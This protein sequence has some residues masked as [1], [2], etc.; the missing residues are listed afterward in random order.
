[1]RRQP[2]SVILFDEIEKAHPDVFNLLLQILEDGILHDGEGRLINFRQT[3]I[4]LT[5]N[6]GSDF[7]SQKINLGFASKNKTS[8]QEITKNV[9]KEIKNILS[10]ELLSRLD[11]KIVFQSLTEK[12]L[13]KITRNELTKLKNRLKNRQY[14][15]TWNTPTIKNIAQQSMKL[16]EGARGIRKIIT[17]QVENLIAEQIIKNPDQKNFKLLFKNKK[18]IIQ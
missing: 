4:I 15:L 8:D 2:Y 18:F 11:N 3:I 6:L 12:S 10:P 7:F 17:A 1:V 9:L 14:N 5:S 13:I 16:K